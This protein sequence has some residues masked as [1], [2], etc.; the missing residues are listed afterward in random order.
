M[1][2]PATRTQAKIKA[3][4]TGPSGSGKT[5][6]ALTIAKSL[7]GKIAVVDS[8]NGSASLYSGKFQ[9]D[10]IVIKPPYTT[11]KY[12]EAIEAAEKAGYS[13]VVLDSITHA[14]SGEG[15]LL[16]QKE[17]LDQRGG[18]SYA[19]WA[20]ITPKQEKFMGKI[21]YSDIHLIATMRSKQDYVLADNG[22]GKMAPQ[23]VGMAPVQREGT[24]YE[25]TV[26][27]DVAMNHEASVSKDRTGLFDGKLFK[28]TEDTG[29]SILNWLGGAEPEIKT[30]D[31]PKVQ[32][33]EQ[34]FAECCSLAMRIDDEVT[35]KKVSDTLLKSKDDLPKLLKIRERIKGIIE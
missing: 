12:I 24:E 4:I 31:E 18:N 28:I 32:N 2:T 9:F 27:F 5:Y 22:K 20:K 34:V 11:E 17:Q 16:Q 26:V 30:D 25:F 1:F 3:A 6:S 21:L 8:E 13:S 10:T 7:G 29:K 33:A 35:A 14:W 23:K 19:N 15:G